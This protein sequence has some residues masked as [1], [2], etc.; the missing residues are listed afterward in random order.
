MDE[1][2]YTY[3]NRMSRIWPISTLFGPQSIINLCRGFVYDIKIKLVNGILCSN[4]I[5]V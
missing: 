2:A 4:D 5:L 1:K 3:F